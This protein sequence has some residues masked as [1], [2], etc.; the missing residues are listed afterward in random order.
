MNINRQR[1]LIFSML[2]ILVLVIF[3]YWSAA[4]GV[5]FTLFQASQPFILGAMIAY[6]VNI[7]MDG[8]ERLYLKLFKSERALKAKRG[9]S[10]T[11]AYS[12]FIIVVIIIMGIVIPELIKAVQSLLSIDP[13]I[14]QDWFEKIED[15]EIVKQIVTVS[16]G[17]ADANLD[18]SSTIADYVQQMISTIGNI[19]LGILTS[20]S[21]VFSA[22]INVLM[23]II[24][25]MYLLSSK[26][27]LA[28]QIKKLMV[29]Y[30]PNS[31]KKI[32]YVLGIFDQSFRGF[33]ISQTIEAVILGVLCFIGMLIFRFPFASTISILTGSANIIPIL[34]AYMGGLVGFILVLT[35]SFSKALLFIV[36][37]NVLQQ[38]ESNLIYPRVVGGSVGLPAMWVLL[39]VSIGGALG[40]VFGMLISVPT[41]AALYKILKI[42]VYSRLVDEEEF[43]E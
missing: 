38:L 9:I 6:I 20:A 34:G 27:R 5:F 28:I 4:E 36:F 19:L 32:E 33:F 16:Q 41:A 42:D 18:I 7:L 25:S 13:Q 11:L 31:Y 14:I 43:D 1:V 24:F 17:N 10:L 37:I 12:T 30:L 21:G 23:G 39:A 2:V 3:R 35:T 15:N 40:G 29:A 8:Y 22:V 26:E